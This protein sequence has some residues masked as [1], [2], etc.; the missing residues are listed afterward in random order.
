MTPLAIQKI[1]M[2]CAVGHSSLSACAAIRA[3]INHFRETRFVGFDGEP[4][5]GAYLDGIEEW[6]PARLAKMFHA[7]VEE[8]RTSSGV[9]WSPETT[10]LFLLVPEPSRPG[11]DDDWPDEILTSCAEETGLTFNRQSRILRAGKAGIGEALLRAHSLLDEQRV[12]HV[13]VLGIDSYL[14][15][16]VVVQ[17]LEGE[18]ILST[19]NR[20]GYIPGEGAGAVLLGLDDGAPG[21]LLI[22]GVGCAEEN[23]RISQSE[24]PIRGLGLKRAIRDASQ[25]SGFAVS[26]CAFHMSDISGESYYFKEASLAIA[27]SLETKVES[28]PHYT[29]ASSIGETGAA[30]GP[31]LLAYLSAVAGRWDS[32]GRRGLLHFSNDDGRRAA[33]MVEY[34]PEP[35]HKKND[36]SF[37]ASGVGR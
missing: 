25:M 5:V 17:H 10:A 15:T 8:C 29:P 14:H 2:C 36:A 18:R 32:P 9:S 24:K 28:F 20:D 4:I 22:T 6:G 33:V 26:E 31:L 13:M 19:E 30:V 1:G 37:V 35:F 27:G 7:V 23:A 12:G 16:D 21:R 34:R 3:N 11:T